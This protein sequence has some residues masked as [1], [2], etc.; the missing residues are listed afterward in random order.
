MDKLLPFLA[1][2]ALILFVVVLN[3]SLIAWARRKSGPADDALSR[4]INAASAARKAREK[5][6]ADL[7]ELHRRVSGL[8]K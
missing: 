5:Q 4:G 1:V 3:L 2:G 6:E 8:K 7:N